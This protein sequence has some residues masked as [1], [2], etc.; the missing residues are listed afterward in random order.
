MMGFRTPNDRSRLRRRWQPH[1]PTTPSKP[2]RLPRMRSS[3]GQSPFRNGVSPQIGMPAAK[4]WGLYKPQ[5]PTL[6]DSLGGEASLGYATG[7]FCQEIILAIATSICRR[8]ARLRRNLFLCFG[9]LYHLQR[10]GGARHEAYPAECP[11]FPAKRFGRAECAAM[12]CD[13]R[14]TIATPTATLGVL[15]QA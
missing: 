14:L 3:L 12:L 11:E 4:A 5:D 10:R 13:E 8:C 6:G 2:Y 15:G 9:N 7:Q 1:R